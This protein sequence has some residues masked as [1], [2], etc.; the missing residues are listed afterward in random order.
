MPWSDPPTCPRENRCQNDDARNG[1]PVSE[2]ENPYQLFADE[3]TEAD[4]SELAHFDCGE[5]DDAPWARAANEWLFGSDVWESK[6]RGTTV[7][8]YRLASGVL[9]GF[10]SLG[11]T[12]RR[13]PPPDG[14]YANLLIIPML[15]IDRQCHAQPP[16][17][18][19]RYS[20]QILNHLLY[21]ASQLYQSEKERGRSIL[22]LL[23]LW[24]HEDNCRA[25]RLYEK[26]GFA[27]VR[28]TAKKPMMLMVRRL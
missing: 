1:F 11:L 22:D 6:K 21:E 2:I 20:R 15:G 10:G 28:S 25:I 27:A 3:F 13:W 8:L 19:M 9:V 7:W 16:D 5:A 23:T 18:E 4:Q 17:E 24:V 12:R 14:G 26:F